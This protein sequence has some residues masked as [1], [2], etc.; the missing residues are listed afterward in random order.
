MTRYMLTLIVTVIMRTLI[1]TKLAVSVVGI[2]YPLH[3]EYALWLVAMQAIAGWA[4]R[5]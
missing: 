1:I 4:T 3:R 2:L 5:P